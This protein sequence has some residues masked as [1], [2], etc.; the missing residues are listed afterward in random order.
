MKRR[1][2][3][4]TAAA[5]A[6][7]LPL[8]A[9][10]QQKLRRVGLL[11]V[12]PPPPKGTVPPVVS[13]VLQAG[14]FVEGQN[15]AYEARY[16]S[17]QLD[18]LPALATEIVQRDVEVIVVNGF[19]A[20]NAVRAATT[21]I[22]IVTANGSGDAVATRVVASYARPGGNITGMSEEAVQL[23][24]K[25]LELLK[26]ALPHA[27]RVAVMWNANDA[28]M[29]LRYNEIE[30]AARAL[31][32]EVQPLGVRGA[33]DF[34]TTLETLTRGK[35]DAV[36]LIA[37]I[38]TISNRKHLLEYAA[39]NRLPTMYEYG[40]VVREGGLMSYG[41]TQE[42]GFR[43]AASYVDRILKGAKAAEL[44]VQQPTRYYLAVNLKTAAAL[45]VTIPPSILVRAD[46]IVQ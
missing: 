2:F 24:A 39:A 5:V 1:R 10:S 42:E 37:D 8:A 15:I 45:G 43:I 22:P 46:D 17:G 9:Y 23:S 38:L 16:A 26:E 36:F 41:S 25:R 30:K 19:R 40:F 18:K 6:T 11:S 14:G 7:L 35:P 4:Y 3:I 29:T 32:I 33:G 31:K 12:G 27:R 28:A 34:H 20:L 44:P 21:T 13:E